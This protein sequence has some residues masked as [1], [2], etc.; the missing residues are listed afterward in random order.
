MP[1]FQFA[2]KSLDLKYRSSYLILYFQVNFI[3]L[4]TQVLLSRLLTTA[5][6]QII[7]SWINITSLVLLAASVFI[8]NP[9]F[10]QW[11]NYV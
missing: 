3:L 1:N 10:I 4:A 8:I 6:V 11:F 7:Y 9:C 2:E 5:F